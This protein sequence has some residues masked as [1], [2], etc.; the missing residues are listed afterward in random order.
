MD[1]IKF[2]TEITNLIISEK[3]EFIIKNTYDDVTAELTPQIYSNTF[4]DVLSILDR[5]DEKVLK[6]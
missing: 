3:I 1:N 6:S 2:A 5:L 4:K